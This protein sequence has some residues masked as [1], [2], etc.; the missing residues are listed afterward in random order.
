[1]V[2]MIVEYNP[3]FGFVGYYLTLDFNVS[4]ERN[5]LSVKQDLRLALQLPQSSSLK[6][7]EDKQRYTPPR[8]DL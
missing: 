7:I 4:K 1:M 3:T 5:M 2:D 8:G 6:S